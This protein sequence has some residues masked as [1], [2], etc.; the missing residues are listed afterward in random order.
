M[1]CIV[2]ET[3]ER[4]IGERRMALLKDLAA[5]NATARTARDACILAT[6]TLATR[7]QDITF[8]LTYLGDELQSCT[9]GA[10]ERLAAARGELVKDLPIFSSGAVAQTG[11]LI[12]GLNPQRPFDDKYRAFL[13]LVVGQLSTAVVNARAYEE[14]RKRAEALAEIDRAKTAFFS[15]VSHEFRTPL[16]LLLGPVQDA[17]ASPE[18]LARSRT[19]SRRC[20][21]MRLR[22][23][24]LVN[25]LLDFARIEAGRAEAI[26]E[27]TDLAGLTADLAGGLSFGH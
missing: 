5:R 10:P 14:E 19:P 7:P 17:L 20:I 2:T 3:T 9:P 25:T 23:L 11:R 27:S 8:A 21:A 24:K 26:Y 15:N 4:V 6:E 12:V 18:A 16:T 1:F 22:L 13:D